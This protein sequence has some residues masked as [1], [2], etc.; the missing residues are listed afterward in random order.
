MGEEVKTFIGGAAE[1]EQMQ[2]MVG[3]MRLALAPI[4]NADPDDIPM[5]Q[6]MAITSAAVFAGMT[7]GHMIAFGT[8][9]D[10]DR[11]RAGELVLKNF[12]TGIDLGK[13]E[14]RQA[15][16]EQLPAGGTA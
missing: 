13:S 4:F 7:V 1:H 3:L 6:S 8:M 2:T 5:H 16:L 9:K 10:Q 11:R 12:R 15:M 14:A